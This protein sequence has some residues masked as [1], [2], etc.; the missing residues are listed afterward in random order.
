MIH[1]DQPHAADRE[2]GSLSLI[3]SDIKQI[4]MANQHSKRLD[5]TMGTP[6]DSAVLI[7]ALLYI[8]S[9]WLSHLKAVAKPLKK[10][11]ILENNR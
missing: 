7:S 9:N 10:T 4:Q 2:G 3:G 1:V 8:S 11:D 5:V 6:Q